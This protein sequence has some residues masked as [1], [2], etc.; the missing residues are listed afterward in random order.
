MPSEIVEAILR[1]VL[2][3][4]VT[5]G[6]IVV[7]R[8]FGKKNAIAAGES[9]GGFTTTPEESEVD[10]YLGPATLG[11]G[12]EALLRKIRRLAGV[13]TVA[14][15]PRIEG[16]VLAIA[17]LF[18]DLVVAYHPDLPG[19]FRRDARRK[20]LESTAEALE[21]IP[22]P[23]TVRAAILR[24]AWLGDLPRVA[25]ARTEVRWWVG[26]ASFVGKEPPK[27]LLAWPEVRRVR[28]DT[29]SVE[30]LRVLELFADRPEVAG[31][32]E[33]HARAFAAFFAA[34]PLTDLTLA[35]RLSPPFVWSESL[36]RLVASPAGARVARR[37]IGFGEERGKFARE[38]I[39]ATAG[40]AAGSIVP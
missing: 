19:L 1:R 9:V 26:G 3:P 25:L 21:S 10:K 36:A 13:D 24:H 30:M 22:K 17:A 15:G 31:L 37:A 8:P 27:R 39:A 16:G 32:A 28:K 14:I 40:E 23:T 11:E 29:R 38:V 33:L 20:L 7:E 5:G 35:G 12:E 34:S 18:H 4:A 6:A 2:V